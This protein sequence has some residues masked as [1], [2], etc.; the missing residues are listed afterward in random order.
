MEKDL[1]LEILTDW[2]IWSKDLDSGIERKGYLEKSMKYLDTNVAIALIGVRRSGKS[3][4]MRQVIK[5]LIR[6]GVDWKETLLI[7]F[8]DQRFNDRS[9]SLLDEVFTTYMAT[10]APKNRPYVFLDEVHNVPGWERWVTTMMELGKAKIFVSGSSSKLL[11]GE[12]ATV[13]TGR[14]LDI[15]VY[16]ASFSEYLSFTGIEFKDRLDYATKKTEIGRS[17]SEY[18]EYG[19]FPEVIRASEKKQLLR[20]YFDDIITKDI[21]K[22]HNLKKAEKLRMLARFCLSNIAAPM[23]YN[24]LKNMLDTSVKTID[25]Y[26]GFLEEANLLFYVKR[27]SH[28]VKEQEKSPRKV[29][30]IDTGLSNAIGF[31]TSPNTGRTA[32]NI[33]AIELAR[34]NQETPCMETYYWKDAIGKEV[35]FVQTDGARIIQLIQVCWNTQDPKTSARENTALLKASAELGCDELLVITQDRNAETKEKGKTIRYAPLWKW[36]LGTEIR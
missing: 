16:P 19:G 30:S 35:D 29:Y 22:R 5:R 18:M 12:L 20:T 11:S 1:L 3:Y 6:E 17:L 9:S 2:N 34:R 15:K 33:V 23:T 10:L 13:L 32:E 24:S 28:K 7:N 14:H 31:K 21:E 26:A 8:E 36:L 4:I 27:Y 25:K